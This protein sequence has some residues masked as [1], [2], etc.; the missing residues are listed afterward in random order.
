MGIL[1]GLKQGRVPIIDAGVD[2]IACLAP[3]TDSG[4]TRRRPGQ[5]EGSNGQMPGSDDAGGSKTAKTARH[6]GPA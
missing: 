6:G 2:G 3:F 5:V 4:R 1:P